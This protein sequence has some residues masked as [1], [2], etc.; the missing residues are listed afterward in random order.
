VIFIVLFISVFPNAVISGSWG[1]GAKVIQIEAIDNWDGFIVYADGVFMSS[2][3]CGGAVNRVFLESSHKNYYIL[4]G[5]IVDAWKNSRTLTPTLTSRC[6]PRN[7][8][9]IDG[10]R[11]R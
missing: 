7:S 8:I 4:F 11:T 9:V 2:N 6:G 5:L 10:V 3:S 1:I